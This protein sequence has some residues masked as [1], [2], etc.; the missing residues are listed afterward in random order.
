MNSSYFLIGA[1][2]L[3]YVLKLCGLIPGIIVL[4]LGYVGALWSFNLLLKADA[5]TGGHK[6]FKGF[7]R[8]CGGAPMKRYYNAIKMFCL[9]GS[10]LSY[11]IMSK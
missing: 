1:L 4:V 10:L 7:A 11:Q 6:T 9:Y 3:P 5:K 2:T 8:A